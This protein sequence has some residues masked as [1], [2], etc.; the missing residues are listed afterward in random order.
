MRSG[1]S[2]AGGM[3]T[4]FFIHFG[5]FPSGL[6]LLSGDRKFKWQQIFLIGLLVFIRIAIRVC[7]ARFEL[8]IVLWIGEQFYNSGICRTKFRFVFF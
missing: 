5:F 6:G 2:D 8:L 1:S 3:R 7:A 4:I